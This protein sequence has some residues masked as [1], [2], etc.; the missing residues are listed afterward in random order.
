[1]ACAAWATIP[2]PRAAVKVYPVAAGVRI[3]WTVASNGPLDSTTVDV[4]G[5][6]TLH[7]KYTALNK[8]D[9]VD[10]AAPAPGQSISGTVTATAWRR[11]LSASSAPAPWSYTEP[12]Q[13]PPPPNV[14][15][16][17]SPISATV[18]PGGTVQFTATVS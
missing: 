15:V 9:S 4:T 18:A 3:K 6:T 13:P 2:T 14:N 11:S 8:V 1:M 16:Q 12:D 5:P 17:V 7:K 10:V